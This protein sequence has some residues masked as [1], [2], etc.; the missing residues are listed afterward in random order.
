MS[1]QIK[2]PVKLDYIKRS[3]KMKIKCKKEQI[4]ILIIKSKLR[5]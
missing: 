4:L 5:H 2:I 3:Q 1:H